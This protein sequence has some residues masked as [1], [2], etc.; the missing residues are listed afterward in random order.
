MANSY[1]L[2][3]QTPWDN[4]NDKQANPPIGYCKMC[5]EEI[6]DQDELDR[7]DG[8]CLPCY[9][10]ALEPDPDDGGEETEGG[11]GNAG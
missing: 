6:Y 4:A 7:N 11:D 1:D 5:G 8:M 9:Y 2:D 10:A 3:F